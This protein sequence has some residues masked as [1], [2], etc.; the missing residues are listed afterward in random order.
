MLCVSVLVCLCVSVLVCVRV[1]VYVCVRLCILSV[2]ACISGAGFPCDLVHYYY[3]TEMCSTWK[4][5]V[6]I[7]CMHCSNFVKIIYYCC[8]LLLL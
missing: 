7:L 8:V 5:F 2:T 3:R 4:S 6:I 1:C